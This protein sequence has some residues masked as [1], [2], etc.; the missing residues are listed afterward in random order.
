[1]RDVMRHVDSLAVDKTHRSAPPAAFM[2]CVQH[3]CLASASMHASTACQAGPPTQETVRCASSAEGPCSRWLTL[4]V[5]AASRI[6]VSRAASL[7]YLRLLSEGSPM[8]SLIF[9]LQHRNYAVRVR[10][11]LLPRW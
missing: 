11:L 4:L 10:D 5:C 2:S 7:W 6:Q 8:K 9:G 3:P 1:M